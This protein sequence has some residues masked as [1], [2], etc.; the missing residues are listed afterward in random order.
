MPGGEIGCVACRTGIRH[1]NSGGDGAGIGP[2]K[3]VGIGIVE[4][5]VLEAF[6]LALNLLVSEMG[7]ELGEIVD[8]ALSMG[9][10]ND[11]FG[12][13]PDFRSNLAPSSFD[14]RNGIGE[15]T[16]LSSE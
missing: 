9:S 3:T 5:G 8:G 4:N 16:V 1:I 13:L 14:S 2:M 10:S 7:F 11:I 12:I 15:S 6:Y